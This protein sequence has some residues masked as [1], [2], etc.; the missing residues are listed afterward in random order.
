VSI[1]AALL[2]PVVGCG[3]ALETTYGRSVGQSVNGTNALVELFKGRG[4]EVKAVRRLTDSLRGQADT[5]VR[6]AY[7]ADTPSIEEA[8]WYESW[9]AGGS[10][11]RLIYVPRDYD[12]APEYWSAVRAKLPPDADADLVAR[13]D[14]QLSQSWLR[15]S[16]APEAPHKALEDDWFAAAKPTGNPTP[17]RKL[18]GPWAEGIDANAAAPLRHRPLVLD[19]EI[20][21]LTGDGKTLAMEWSWPS[22]AKTLVVASGTFLL[23]G[24]LLNRARRPLAERVV[25]WSGAPP[26]RV[27]FV[28]G[29]FVL[30][31]DRRTA[32]PFALL[33]VEPIGWVG[34]H[35]L[36]LLLIGVLVKAPILGRPRP[37]ATADADRPSAHAEALGYLLARTRDAVAAR[38]H[39]EAYRRWRQP[40]AAGPNP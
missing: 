8:S 33:W 24:A 38:S 30:V 1:L 36:L 9:L 10:D 15:Q 25:D 16:N 40:S 21:L 14:Y 17:C 11:R 20:A 29:P 6:F 7:T 4:H 32:S 2:L 3:P 13:V 22:G 26:R 35:L 12:A 34:V 19:A 23:N 39:L 27:V 5:I 31:G 37:D 18:A 28:E